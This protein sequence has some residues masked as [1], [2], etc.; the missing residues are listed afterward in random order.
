M[1]KVFGQE[2]HG[3]F[4]APKVI[5]SEILRQY[6]VKV[7]AVRITYLDWTNWLPNVYLSRRGEF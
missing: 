1:I 2:G 4:V 5:E 6:Q 7:V 3:A